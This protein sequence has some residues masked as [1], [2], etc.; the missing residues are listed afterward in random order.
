MLDSFALLK[1]N[2]LYL[3]GL[4]EVVH[5]CLIETEQLFLIELTHS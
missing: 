2:Y 5:Q 3:Q 4:I 1:N